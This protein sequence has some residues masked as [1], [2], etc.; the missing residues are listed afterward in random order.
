MPLWSVISNKNNR[1]KVLIFSLQVVT[2]WNL[3]EQFC[4]KRMLNVLFY[5]FWFLCFHSDS[6]NPYHIGNKI[7]PVKDRNFYETF[8]TRISG[9]DR[10]L[11]DMQLVT[12][13]EN[14]RGRMQVFFVFFC[15]FCTAFFC[16]IWKNRAPWVQKNTKKTCILPQFLQKVT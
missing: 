11:P 4:P 13:Y 10:N 1:Q 14:L 16:T 15:I 7:L 3:S 2:S 12:I 6:R 9:H 5:P 8:R